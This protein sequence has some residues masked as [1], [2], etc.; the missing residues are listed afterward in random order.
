MQDQIKFQ[1]SEEFPRGSFI[2][3]AILKTELFSNIKAIEA[4]LTSYHFKSRGRVFNVNVEEPSVELIADYMGKF[5]VSY[6]IGQFNA[7]ADVDFTERA[8]MEML[9]DIDIKNSEAIIT[10]EYIPEREPD[11]F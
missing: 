9:I 3:A 5:L 2:N 7:C 11:E 10:G 6:T 8:S 1:L 4:L